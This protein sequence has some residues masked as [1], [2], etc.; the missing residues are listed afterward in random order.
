MPETA[1][2][3]RRGEGPARA[4]SEAAPLEHAAGLAA[5]AP[6]TAL[7]RLEAGPRGLTEA[8]AADRLARYGENAPPSWR[9]PSL[10]RR[11]GRGVRDPFTAVLL[12]LAVVS[13]AVGSLGAAGVIAALVTVSCV[14][15]ASGELRADRSVAGLRA[16]LAGTVTVVRRPDADAARPLPREVPV[17]DLVP[18]DVIRLGPGDLVP[19]DVLLLRSTGLVVHQ[20]PL[21]GESGPLPK[22]RADAAA[23]PPAGDTALFE[24]PH[25]CFQGSSVV[26]GGGTAV[27]IATGAATRLAAG[28]GHARAAHGAFDR[29]VR[30]V[31]RALVRFMLLTPPLALAADA[32]VSG[33]GVQILPF[34]V[35]VAVSLT[36]EMLPVV[37]TAVLARGA[38]SLAREHRVIVRRLS[39]LPDLGA[40]DVLCLDKT[41]TLTQDRPVV[42][43]ALGADLRPDPAVLRWAALNALWTVQLA[44]NPV[45]DAL[46]EAVL[47]AA[48]RAAG[49]VDG[50]GSEPGAEAWEGV[51]ALPF[52]PARRLS[53]AVVREPGRLGVHTLVVKGAVDTVLE[54]CAL[55]E[56]E[57]E[58]L[59]AVAARYASD[60]LRLLAVAT[61]ERGSR[62]DGRG[63]G[64]AD[65]RGLAFVGL[66]TLRDSL[67]EDAPEV[68][69]ALSG[70][71]VEVKVLTGD[72]PG[73]AVR[74]CRELGLDPGDDVLTAR[75]IDALGDDELAREAGR[76]RLFARCT[77][78]HKA[79]V[80]AALQADGRTTGFL[81]DGVNDLAALRAA[82]VALC[83]RDAVAPARESAD[84]V[85]GE[86]PFAG[87][88]HALDAGRRA[89]VSLTAYL[90]VTLSSQLG[91]A[92]AMLAAALLLP[93]VPML[94]A[95]V[96]VQNLFFDAAQL[97]FAFDRRG[98]A[99]PGRPAALRPGQ[100]LRFI[101]AFG[102]LN[103]AADLATFAVL[104][105]TVRGAADASGQALFHAGWFTENLLTQAMVMV[106]LR[107]VPRLR[108]PGLPGPVALAALL[109]AATGIL[110]PLTALGPFLGMVAA[111][112]PLSYALLALVLLLYGVALAAAMRR[113]ARE[114]PTGAGASAGCMVA[115]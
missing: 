57:R 52:D 82:D 20:A 44:E 105:L 29:S 6:L 17:G 50:S 67:T 4:R 3:S 110:L 8:E 55:P 56:A 49:P 72:D 24:Q 31:A 64:V 53:T 91:N 77:P 27:V 28:H 23:V 109:L 84:V 54:R 89:G 99:S 2:L 12:C 36:P 41:G 35:A 80:V 22:H 1:G 90:R 96:L 15:R 81:G 14:L 62:A 26:A 37:T 33:H 34:A 18:G 100:I 39:A 11:L 107:T 103:A 69:R 38:V 63:V 79:R 95:Q 87:L 61:A 9:T 76:V 104:A 65:E 112:T 111:L 7:R 45:P 88:G 47:H 19:A 97:T 113:Y 106:L 102:V 58:A 114:E 40:M 70:R 32:A 48:A 42:D 94:P 101:T 68:L 43:Q 93:F 10:W 98:S 30:G 85:L 5:H 13:T 75:R 86:R 21:T 73:T 78:R 74:T 60:G 16:L 46:D 115:Q 66:V 51:A 59:R 83:P 25:L 71:G 92:L 108:R